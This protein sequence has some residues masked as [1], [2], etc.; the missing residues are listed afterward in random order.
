MSPS[1]FQ[2]LPLREINDSRPTMPATIHC[3]SVASS[4]HVLVSPFSSRTSHC[5]SPEPAR[6][7]EPECGPDGRSLILP[8]TSPAGD[9]AR[10]ALLVSGCFDDTGF[11][12]LSTVELPAAG[13]ATPTFVFARLRIL[14]MCPQL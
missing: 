14:N 9:S 7:P 4:R 6:P 3:C 11:G 1:R 2:V 5:R 10:G 8:G 12:R 13:V